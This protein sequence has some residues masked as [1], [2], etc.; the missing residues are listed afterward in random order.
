[1]IENAI[2]YTKQSKPVFCVYYLIS[3]LNI[4]YVGKTKNIKLR[5][6]EHK[7]KTYNSVFYEEFE[8]YSDLYNAERNMIRK[9][10]P[11]YN[12]T[13]FNEF[14]LNRILTFRTKD[15]TITALKKKAKKMDITINNLINLILE[16]NQI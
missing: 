3:G 11:L 9:Y 8:T 1:M 7:N 12:K 16:S 13:G 15:S 4:V 10:K 2:E 5:L 6:L 14:I